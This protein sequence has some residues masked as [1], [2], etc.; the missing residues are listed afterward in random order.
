MAD[1][2]TTFLES[3]STDDRQTLL[4]LGHRREWAPGSVLVRTGEGADSAIVLLAGLVK[5]H[6]MASGGEEVLFAIAG[7]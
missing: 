4:S 2:H 6:K 1:P 5:I 3:L 7:A